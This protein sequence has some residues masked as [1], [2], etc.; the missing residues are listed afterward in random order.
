MPHILLLGVVI[1]LSVLS[2]DPSFILVQV[3]QGTGRRVLLEL[4]PDHG[5]V[6]ARSVVVCGDLEKL[7]SSAFINFF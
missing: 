1:A 5:T 6:V 2:L 4:L 7:C 3:R